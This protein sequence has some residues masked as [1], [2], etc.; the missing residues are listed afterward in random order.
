MSNSDPVG[1]QRGIY[2]KLQTIEAQ[3]DSIL[4][5]LTLIAASAGAQL[6]AQT[7]ASMNQQRRTAR[8]HAAAERRRERQ[9]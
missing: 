2:A 4:S 7:I 8:D 3:N 5:I 9:S 6:D 1:W